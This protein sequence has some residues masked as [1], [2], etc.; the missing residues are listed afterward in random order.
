MAR[1]VRDLARTTT[2]YCAGLG[3]HVVG[4]FENHEGF[5]GVMLGR[6]N[7]GYHF[8]FTY[9]R[10]HPVE[11]QWTAEDLVVFCLPD[12]AEWLQACQAM[13][14]GGFRRVASF[15][16]YRDLQG[17]TLEDPDGYRHHGRH[18]GHA[19]PRRRH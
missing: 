12:K 17:A 3:L 5:D 15:N 14:S 16:P 11:P 18:C 1:P 9:C 10:T 19:L 7:T 8:E 13:E 6:A 4:R 2:L